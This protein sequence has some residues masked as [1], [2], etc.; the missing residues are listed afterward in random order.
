M[1]FFLNI[2]SVQKYKYFFPEGI[3]DFNFSPSSFDEVMLISSI[4]VWG[5]FFGYYLVPK[6]IFKINLNLKNIENF[7]LRNSTIIIYIVSLVIII[8]TLINF[9]FGIFQ[10][11][12][13]SNLFL[14]NIFRNLIAFFFMIGFGTAVAFVINFELNRKR[15]NILY[16]SLLETFFTSFSSL[17][18]YDI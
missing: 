11:G 5:F 3:G 17:S 14:G 12:F 16:L 2:I 7:Y 9:I 10:K 18:S 4:G 1:V 6:N 15:Y 8:F 13:V